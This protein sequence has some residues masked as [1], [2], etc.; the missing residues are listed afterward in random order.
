MKAFFSSVQYRREAI[1]PLLSN[2]HQRFIVVQ[3]SERD[4]LG[5]RG[6]HM[7]N[8]FGENHIASRERNHEAGRGGRNHEGGRLVPEERDAT[9]CEEI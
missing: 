7:Y 9:Q 5:M 6:R 1:S 8:F 3:S 2:L 4:L